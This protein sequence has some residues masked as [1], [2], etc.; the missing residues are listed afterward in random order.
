[1]DIVY[2]DFIKVFDTVSHKLIIN[3]P[4]M[5]GLDEQSVKWTENGLNGWTHKVV[6]NGTKSSWMPVTSNVPQES[7]LD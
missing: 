3:K 1:M 2:L 4:L 7:I 5:Y 6:I